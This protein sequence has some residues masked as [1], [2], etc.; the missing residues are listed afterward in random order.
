V[1]PIET[2]DSEWDDDA[3]APTTGTHLANWSEVAAV[4]ETLSLKWVLPVLVE[5]R[6]GALRHS[7]V[8]RALHI[9]GKQV[10]RILRRLEEMH[11]VA[12]DVHVSRRPVQ[13]RYHLTPSGQD[14]VVILA[15]L[16]SWRRHGPEETVPE[17]ADGDTAVPRSMSPF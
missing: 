10:S 9:D 3:A 1:K 6:N 8:A 16:G 13:V 17:P 5:L 12:R 7:E 14:L 15:D 4:I 2:T 11:I